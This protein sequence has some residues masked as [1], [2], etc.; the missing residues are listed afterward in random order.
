L[1][2]KN[3]VLAVYKGPML[4]INILPKTHILAWF[5]VF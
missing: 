4:K 5:R 1:G 2:Q 3:Y